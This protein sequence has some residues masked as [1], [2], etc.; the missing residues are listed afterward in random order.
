M[1]DGTDNGESGSHRPLALI[2]MR[3]G[4]SEVG[5]HSVAPEVGNVPLEALD[6]ACDRV[7]VDANDVTHFLRAEP[8]AQFGRINEVDEHCGDLPPFSI[9]YPCGRWLRFQLSCGECSG[10]WPWN[11]RQGRDRGQQLATGPDR[12]H[13]DRSEILRSQPG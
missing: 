10:S 11:R 3:L 13:A 12:G 2:L 9:R 6:F 1:G 4:P 5:E 8:A 7:L